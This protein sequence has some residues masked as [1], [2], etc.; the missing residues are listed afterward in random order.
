MTKSRI[1]VFAQTNTYFA[2]FW[3]LEKALFIL[4]PIWL[5]FITKTEPDTPNYQFKATKVMDFIEWKK[6]YPFFLDSD[7][8]I[9]AFHRYLDLIMDYNVSHPYDLHRTKDAKGVFSQ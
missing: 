8:I 4:L 6:F 3:S 2:P 9:P 1:S 7:A 5:L